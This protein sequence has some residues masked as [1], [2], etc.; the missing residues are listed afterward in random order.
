MVKLP[1]P[2]FGER[3]RMKMQKPQDYWRYSHVGMMF[4]T[5]F[6][7]CF[8]LGHYVDGI[9]KTQPLFTLLGFG[10]G[11]ASGMKLL[12]QATGEHRRK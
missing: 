10:L 12:L 9:W 11:F 3:T 8:C 5:A 4:I 2:C 7:V 6:A 1:F